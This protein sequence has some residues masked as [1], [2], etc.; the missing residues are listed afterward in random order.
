MGGV[1][2]GVGIG[3]GRG[4]AGRVEG[5]DWVRLRGMGGR[6]TPV[7]LLAKGRRRLTRF[8]RRSISSRAVMSSSS[9]ERALGLGGEVRGERGAGGRNGLGFGVDVEAGQAVQAAVAAGRVTVA[10]IHP[11]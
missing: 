9:A 3:V 5:E 4:K 6:E 1:E 7:A 11:R 10:G 2:V 8:L